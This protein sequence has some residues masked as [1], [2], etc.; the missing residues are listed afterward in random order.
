MEID[1]QTETVKT[2]FGNIPIGGFFWYGDSLYLKPDIAGCVNELKTRRLAIDLKTNM[3]TSFGG[4]T[5][6]VTPEL[7]PMKIS[8]AKQEK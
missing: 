6:S 3:L 4:D 1:I 2:R 5:V 8:Y 7:S